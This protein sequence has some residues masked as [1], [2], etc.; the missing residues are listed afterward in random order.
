MFPRTD[1]LVNTVTCTRSQ[2]GYI[3]D[4]EKFRALQGEELEQLQGY[5]RQHTTGISFK[6]R[7]KL[8][9]NAFCV[10]MIIHVLLCL[11][12]RLTVASFNAIPSRLDQPSF[13]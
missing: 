12:A 11:R 7:H 8:L 5:P 4:G 13:D 9:G 1:G 10:P 2:K 3:Y 6:K